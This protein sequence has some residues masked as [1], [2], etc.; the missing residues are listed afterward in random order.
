MPQLLALGY[1]EETIQEKLLLLKKRPSISKTEL[2]YLILDSRITDPFK[3]SFAR[4]FEFYLDNYL[5]ISAEQ[6]RK[7]KKLS[8]F[9]KHHRSM[10]SYLCRLSPLNRANNMQILQ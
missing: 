1:T 5:A 8:T 7:I 3:R 10:T 4:F 2:F 6:S 9:I